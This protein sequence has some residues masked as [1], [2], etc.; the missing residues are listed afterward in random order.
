[1]SHSRFELGFPRH[2]KVFRLSDAAYRLWTSAIDYAREQRTNGKIDEADL[3][4]IPRGFGLGS[5]KVSHAAEL[6][7]A[8][9]W[10]KRPDCWQIHDFLTWQ[11]SADQV[12]EQRAKA[13][14]RMRRVREQVRQNEP[15]KFARTSREVTP[16]DH[17]PPA[18]DLA[19]GSFPRATTDQVDSPRDVVGLA[20]TVLKNPYDG[21]YLQPSQW[22]EVVVV[23]AAWSFGNP[24]RLGNS[25]KSDSDLRTILE[26]L[27][28]GNP[29]QD[30]ILAGERAQRDPYFADPKRKAPAAFTAAVVRRLLAA[31]RLVKAE[32]AIEAPDIRARR[33]AGLL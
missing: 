13:R 33:E 2:R 5:W 19:S 18:S 7:K 17:I 20:Q 29:V 10:E 22:P 28:A 23:A 3:A 8:G 30:L 15:T 26:A 16:T 25:P 24:M 4:A 21:E 1:M 6:V 32:P 9:L 11:D 14:E 27:A 12:N 31:P